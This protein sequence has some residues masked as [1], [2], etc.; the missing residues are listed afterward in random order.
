M[1]KTINHKKRITFDKTIN[2][3][4]Q[5]KQKQIKKMKLVLEIK[6]ILH[7]MIKSWAQ[8]IKKVKIKQTQKTQSKI[9]LEEKT[10]Q[11]F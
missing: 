6:A 1:V 10:G 2:I 11:V 7:M 3:H 4:I 9:I 8:I 5:M